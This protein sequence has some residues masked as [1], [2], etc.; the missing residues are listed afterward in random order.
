MNVLRMVFLIGLFSCP[1]IIGAA[2][3]GYFDGI[4]RERIVEIPYVATFPGP[5]AGSNFLMDVVENALFV[6]DLNSRTAFFFDLAQKKILES[7]RFAKDELFAGFARDGSVSLLCTNAIVSFKDFREFRSYLVDRKATGERKS[8]SGISMVEKPERYRLR[9][10]GNGTLFVQ[11]RLESTIY[12]F[13]PGGGMIDSYPCDSSFEATSSGTFIA[14]GISGGRLV[15][16]EFRVEKKLEKPVQREFKGL[17]IQSEDWNFPGDLVACDDPGGGVTLAFYPP[18]LDDSA[19]VSQEKAIGRRD[20][21]GTAS[22]ERAL[23]S[24]K[25]DPRN[26]IFFEKA[27]SSTQYVV[28]VDID[29]QGRGE[30]IARFPFSE[31]DGKMRLKGGQLFFLAPRI[32]REGSWSGFTLYQKR[33]PGKRD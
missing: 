25:S 16:R 2:D 7:F 10:G 23:D 30:P 8:L 9:I 32:A 15:V 3:V 28:V 31:A 22:P 33:L 21:A 5:A 4:S 19:E 18:G 29:G 24:L 17:F 14:P 11:D 20:W 12:A 27:A 1:G 13:T 6:Q 26:L